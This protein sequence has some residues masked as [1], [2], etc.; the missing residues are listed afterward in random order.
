[1]EI[2]VQSGVPGVKTGAYGADVSDA[3]LLKYEA[4]LACHQ[5]SKED[6]ISYLVQMLNRISLTMHC[7]FLF[8]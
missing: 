4:I 8:N 3:V 2:S 5:V 1:M 7:F 6:L